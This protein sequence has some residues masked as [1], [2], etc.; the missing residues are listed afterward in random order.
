MECKTIGLDTSMT[1]TGYSIFM[2]GEYSSSGK[3]DV[4]HSKKTDD[5]IREMIQ[6]LYELIQ[7]EKPDICV[8]ET[9]VVQRNAKTQRN[10]TYIVGAIIGKC[11]ENNIFYYS[12][13]P[14]EWRKMI[15]KD[16]KLPR[17]REELKKWGINKAKQLFNIEVDND[18]ISDAILVGQAY[19]NKFTG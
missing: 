11:I 12:F 3:I 4:S 17:K 18:N 9:P 5:K 19:I 7:R 2:N 13:R 14:S 15:S 1:S 6:E 10:L 16:E 8:W